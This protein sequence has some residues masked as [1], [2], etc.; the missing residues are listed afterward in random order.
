[1]DTTERPGFTGFHHV[2]PAVRD[3]PTS[4]AWYERVL[5]LTRTSTPCP[6]NDDAAVVLSDPES[7]VTI[8]LRDPG[9][10]PRQGHTA[11]SVASRGQLDSWAGWLDG[12]GVAH[13]GVVEVTEPEPYAYLVFRDPD[14]VPLV[15]VHV[16]G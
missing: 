7:G 1:V 9:G 13:E 16:A 3:L 12:I 15:L 10:A 5:G 8:S 6:E 11:F 2:A 4:A 14:D